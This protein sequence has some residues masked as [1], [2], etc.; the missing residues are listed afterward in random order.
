[1][2]R[3]SFLGRQYKPDRLVQ[4]QKVILLEL[5]N[6]NKKHRF[7]LTLRENNRQ[8]IRQGTDRSILGN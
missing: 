2:A 7:G 1:M 5:R 4:L 6:L 8:R 3:G